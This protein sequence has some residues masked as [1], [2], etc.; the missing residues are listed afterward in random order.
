VFKPMLEVLEDRT[1]PSNA[2]PLQTLGQDVLGVVNAPT[3][4]LLGRPLI[5]NGANG[6]PGTGQAGGPG[7]ILFGNGGAGGS[8]APGQAG[9][10]GGA[11][12]LIGNGGAGGAGGAGANGGSGGTGGMLFGNGGN[13]GSGGN[14]ALGGVFAAAAWDG[15]ADFPQYPLNLL[16]DLNALAGELYVHGTYPAPMDLP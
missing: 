2:S 9:G 10:A 7:G 4:A 5:G 14:G 6:A 1:M 15:L 12:G 16:A 3:E 11:A 8:G 13:G